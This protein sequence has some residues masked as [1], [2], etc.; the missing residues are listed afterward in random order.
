LTNKKPLPLIN[1]FPQGKACR[2]ITLYAQYV[3]FFKN[4]IDRQQVESWQEEFIPHPIL[5]L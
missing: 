1:L 5:F 3:A 4:P 2:D